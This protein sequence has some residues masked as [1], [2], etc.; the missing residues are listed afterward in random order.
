M[1]TAT[2]KLRRPPTLR[3]PT[4][5]A[6]S[7]SVRSVVM[8][9]SKV[10]DTLYVSGYEASKVKDS[11]KRVGV[12]HILNLAG[13]HKCPPLHHDSFTYS[14]ISLPDSPSVDILFFI[15]LALE[16]IETAESQ[17]GTVLVHC[18][19]GQSRAPAIACAY[20][21]WKLALS[22]SEAIERVRSAH[23]SADPNLG[24]AM[25][26]EQFRQEGQHRVYYYNPKFSLYQAFAANAASSSLVIGNSHCELRLREDCGEAE[27]ETGS[28]CLSLLEKFEGLSSY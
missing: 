17:G 26:L 15:Y 14:S 16:F 11:L 6:T 7:Q 4:Q 2:K 3:L 12:T 8:P 19:R 27:R 5:T 23:P 22:F 18:V 10:S 21:M 13:E 24:F 25:Q 20:L 28:K 1:S 9:P